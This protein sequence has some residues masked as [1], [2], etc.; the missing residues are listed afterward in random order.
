MSS[1]YW[2][3]CRYVKRGFYRRG[4]KDK[5]S[6]HIT[7]LSCSIKK[8]LLWKKL[9]TL[10]NKYLGLPIELED[11]FAPFYSSW[12]KIYVLNI[13]ISTKSTATTYL[14]LFGRNKKNVVDDRWPHWKIRDLSSKFLISSLPEVSTAC[15]GVGQGPRNSYGSSRGE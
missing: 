7:R 12:T 13:Y 6:F 15:R 10:H 3:S 5:S 1:L 8:W 9:L 14:N 4:N 2:R 11:S